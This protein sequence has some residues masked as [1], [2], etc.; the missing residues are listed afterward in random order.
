MGN[1]VEE[2][3]LIY[4]FTQSRMVLFPVHMHCLESQCS[5]SFESF[6]LFIVMHGMWE[7]FYH[8]PVGTYTV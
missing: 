2:F 1:N 4:L 5:I 6:S 8:V 3:I 7:I